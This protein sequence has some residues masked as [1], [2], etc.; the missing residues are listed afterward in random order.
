MVMLMKK[1]AYILLLGLAGSL[2]TFTSATAV[3]SS[4]VTTKI[5][6]RSGQPA[7]LTLSSASSARHLPMRDGYRSETVELPSG[8]WGHVSMQSRKQDGKYL[9]TVSEGALVHLS[10]LMPNKDVKAKVRVDGREVGFVDSEG[11]AVF[12]AEVGQIHDVKIEQQWLK[13]PNAK[14]EDIDF[15][16]YRVEE[17]SLRE[18]ASTSTSLQAVNT[19]VQTLAVALPNQTTVRY[20][21]FIKNQ[22]VEAP[23]PACILLP[24]HTGTPYFGGNYRTYNPDSSEIKTFENL[25]IN[26]TGSSVNLAK[27][28]GPTKLY[29]LVGPVYVYNG[30]RSES[31]SSIKYDALTP[32]IGQQHA[33]TISADSVNPYCPGALP[34]H[35]SFTGSVS[36][37]GS[38][39]FSGELRKVPNH[40]F[41][42]K[43][44]I[45]NSWG[46][47]MQMDIDSLGFLCLTPGMNCTSSG[48]H[49]IGN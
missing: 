25:T 15:G 29:F 19:A 47:I 48:F 14:P 3:P 45:N 26:W 43:D 36:R 35:Y 34:I 13:N 24:L 37:S 2:F 33:F 27:S 12:T 30:V 4:E 39:D 22:F 9:A 46:T 44:D 17:L 49:F 31:T 6:L 40:E 11:E 23:R 5:S 38:Y 20:Q 21:T 32:V 8:G 7:Y 18:I 41:Y 10:W 42:I 28:I 16:V 1:I